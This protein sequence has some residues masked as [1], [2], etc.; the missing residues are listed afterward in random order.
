MVMLGNNRN[1]TG[2]LG[3]EG[4]HRGGRG[5]NVD[6]VGRVDEVRVR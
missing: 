6:G 4:S 5:R 1:T 3:G 2:R